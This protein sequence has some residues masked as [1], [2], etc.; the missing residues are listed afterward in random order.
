M[1]YERNREHF[2]IS[3]G[4]SHACFFGFSVWSRLIT[5]KAC[6]GMHYYYYD[7]HLHHHHHHYH[8]PYPYQYYYHYY[9]HHHSYNYNYSYITLHDSTLDKMQH[10]TA[11]H[12][13]NKHNYN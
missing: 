13:K 3:A 5:G 9:Y 10:I 11:T 4:D 6:R 12:T 8:Y 1:K 7:D 2:A